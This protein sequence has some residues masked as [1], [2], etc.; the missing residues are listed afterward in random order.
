VKLARVSANQ[1]I[2]FGALEGDVVHDFPAYRDYPDAF[3]RFATDARRNGLSLDQWAQNLLQTGKFETC[4]VADLE[5]AGAAGRS[6]F[7]PPV[8]PEQAWAAAFTYPCPAGWNKYAA[9]RSAKLPILFFKGTASHCVGQ[10]DFIGVRADSS[11]TIPEPELAVILDAEGTILAYTI[12]NDVTALDFTNTSPLHIA[13]SKTYARS[14]ALGPIAVTPPSLPDPT[15]LDIR[16][17]VHRNGAVAAEGASNTSLLIRSFQDLISFTVAHNRLS[18]G[19]VLCTGGGVWLPFD[20]TLQPDDI[21]EIEIE[22]I[23]V[24]RNTAVKV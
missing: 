19:C 18:V 12:A 9:E 22:H 20:F 11:H 5:A 4:R 3:Q 14:L 17:A 15:N 24:L 7:L 23:G 8:L 2:A 1:H 13:Y 10:D 16:I 6:P 21:V